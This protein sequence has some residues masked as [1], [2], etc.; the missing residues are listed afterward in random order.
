MILRTIKRQ[1]LPLSSYNGAC[2]GMK[3]VPGGEEG[4]YDP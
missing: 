4:R 1:A 3:E 2:R